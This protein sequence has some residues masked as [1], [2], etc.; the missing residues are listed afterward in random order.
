MRLRFRSGLR[1]FILPAAGLMLATL[2]GGNAFSQ[3][4]PVAASC[5]PTQSADFDNNTVFESGIRTVTIGS[6]TNA[7]SANSPGGTTNGYTD[8]S[9]QGANGFKGVTINANQN[10]PITI[11]TGVNV[12]E[13][14]RVYL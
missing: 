3:A 9:C 10:V 1:A 4:C 11:V 5:N 8:Y 6:M 12:P 13:N 2:S 14:I 7:S